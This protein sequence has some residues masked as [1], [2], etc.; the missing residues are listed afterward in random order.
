[1]AHLKAIDNHVIFQFE[2]EKTKHLGV[3][4][5]QEKTNWG[6][7]FAITRDG[8]EIGRWVRVIAVGPNC[9]PEIQPGMRVCVDKLKWTTEVQFE[10]EK[11]WRTDSEQILL[12]EEPEAA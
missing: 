8:M 9:D 6:F 1:M 2:E 4:Q 10:G 12:T 7:E 3:N 5:F 11:Y